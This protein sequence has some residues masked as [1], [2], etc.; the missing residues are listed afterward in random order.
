MAEKFWQIGKVY[1]KHHFA[2][3]ILAALLLCGAAPLIM[4]ME[5]LD[6]R[7]SAQVMEMYLSVVGI[8]LLVPLFWPDQNRDIRD[9]LAS[10]E[11][12]MIQLHLVKLAESVMV[13][14]VLILGFLLW[15]RYGECTFDF[16]K[17]FLGTFANCLFLG[18]MGVFIYGIFDNLPVGFM[19]PMVYYI[20]N[21]GAGK[22]Y[23]GPFYL[24]SMITGSF[25][26][27]IWLGAAGILLL[28][29]GI[30]WRNKKNKR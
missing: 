13:L 23:L 5:A 11:T 6:A 15:M 28:A 25:R 1:L 30:F 7:Q 3:Y 8:I 2:G 19:V 12:P 22:K 10:K 4:G 21:Y 27:K 16:L 9:L 20:C 29:A 18:G 17:S 14:A 26:E 24:F